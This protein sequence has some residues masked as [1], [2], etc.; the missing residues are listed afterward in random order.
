MKIT[1]TKSDIDVEYNGK[2][3]RFD[4]ELGIKGFY[5]ISNSMRWLPPHDKQAVTLAD[6]ME[7]IKAVRKESQGRD[8]QIY[9]N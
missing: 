9:F 3:A 2:T 8:F 4:G 1:G 7:I 5:A 6:R